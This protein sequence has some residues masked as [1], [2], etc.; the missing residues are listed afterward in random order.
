MGFYYSTIHSI[1]KWTLCRENSFCPS[2][3]IIH[4]PWLLT[5]ATLWTLYLTPMFSWP[6]LSTVESLVIK[7]SPSFAGLRV[8]NWCWLCVVSGVSARDSTYSISSDRSSKDS[9]I[10][11]YIHMCNNQH[12]FQN[13]GPVR[14]GEHLVTSNST[15][16]YQGTMTWIFL[17][18]QL[19]FCY[20]Y[21]YDSHVLRQSYG[22]TLRLW[23]V[24]GLETYFLEPRPIRLLASVTRG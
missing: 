20:L 3:Q 18:N 22:T 11:Y 2:I 14:E 21:A 8:R 6:S 23:P 9:F 19:G 5:K 13:L 17:R 12:G 1:I 10:L 24:T 16:D 4:I 15:I 7:C